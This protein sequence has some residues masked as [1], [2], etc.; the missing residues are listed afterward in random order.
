MNR[1]IIK[2]ALVCAIS[3]NTILAQAVS[4]SSPASWITQRN[5]TV[6]IRAQLDTALIK[7]KAVSVSLLQVNDGKKKVIAKKNL[8]ITDNVM[9]LMFAK[10]GK[11]LLGGKEFLR[12]EWAADNEKGVIEPIGILDLNK[13]SKSDTVKAL[14]VQDGAEAK[15]V[16]D[17][18][19]AEQFR[20]IGSVEFGT[21]WNK[22]AFF[23]VM[24]KSQDSSTISFAFDGKNGKNAF[25]SYPDR[26]I[27]YI[28]AKDSLNTTCYVREI[29]GDTLKYKDKLWNSEIEKVAADEK[30]IIRMPWADIGV[31]PFEERM[32]GIGV[33][34]MQKGKVNAAIPQNAQYYI[35]GTW[36]DV[37]L[38]K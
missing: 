30:V 28:P 27:S 36:G 33:F 19:K 31:I 1:S 3:V 29:K 20:K 26:I 10:V 14:R 34:A 15:T 2:A 21:A 37:F 5:D 8:K 7:K 24:K 17:I 18:I 35:P 11:D 4:F 13:V 16:A 12:L 25:L 23:I 9:E 6:F 32:I 38:Q 22:D